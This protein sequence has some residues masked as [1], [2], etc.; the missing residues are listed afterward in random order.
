MAVILYF[1]H[2]EH[3]IYSFLFPLFRNGFI[4]RKEAKQEAHDHIHSGW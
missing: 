1:H 4:E 3:Y 2:R